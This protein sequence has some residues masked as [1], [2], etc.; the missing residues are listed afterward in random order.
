[1]D[2]TNAVSDDSR[3]FRIWELPEVLLYRIST[4]TVPPTERAGF[5]CH[6]IA[7][8]CRPAY[9]SILGDDE[10]SNLLWSLVLKGDYGV[11]TPTGFEKNPR[12][13]C[14]RLKR[15]PVDQVR[16][17]HQVLRDTTELAYYDLWEL[18]YSSQSS[19]SLTKGK[20]CRIL[21]EYGPNLL[22]NRKM[23]GGGTYLVEVCRAKN[24]TCSSV[25]Q[26]VQELVENHA[27][28]VNL[29]TNESANSFLTP[30]C[31]A[32]VRAMPRVVE[33]LLS[34][35]A[36]QEIRCSARFRLFSKKNRYM[37]CNNATPLEFAT[38]ML[39]AERKEGATEHDLRDLKR[40]VKLLT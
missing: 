1:M 28:M 33:Y 18:S 14:K 32:A 16:S 13:S 38:A 2:E 31:V 11:D 39:E 12:R 17:A 7:P 6:K 10:K 20:L 15:S 35:G 36:S 37:R 8:L 3:V 25:L 9:Q 19:N 26:C 23:L 40:C 4:Y 21:N 22:I 29:A 5:F 27:A 24:T 30:L 34:K